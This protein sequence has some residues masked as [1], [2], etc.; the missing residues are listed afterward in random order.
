MYLQQLDRETTLDDED[1]AAAPHALKKA[2]E[3][4]AHPP[5]EELYDL[6]NDPTELVNLAGQAD[7]A[8][9]QK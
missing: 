7:L 8:D 1:F 9:I 3:R 5:R 2:L 6:Q 4:S